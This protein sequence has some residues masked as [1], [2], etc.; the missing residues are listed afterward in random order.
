M[1]KMEK[2]NQHWHQR[3]F[4]LP[5]EKHPTIERNELEWRQRLQ[6]IKDANSKGPMVENLM[7]EIEKELHEKNKGKTAKSRNKK[8][9]A[10]PKRAAM[11][12]VQKEL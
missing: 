1:T 12:K 7:R 8:V 4:D 9:P 2:L 3:E 5:R 11:A 10:K 6:D